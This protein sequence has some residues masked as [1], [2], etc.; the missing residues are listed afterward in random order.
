M[1]AGLKYFTRMQALLFQRRLSHEVNS[2]YIR[3]ANFFKA[4]NLP[5]CRIDNVDQRVTTDVERF[6]ESASA[7]LTTVSKPLL[8]VILL[9]TRLGRQ[10]GVHAPAVVIGASLLL[11]QLKLRLLPDVKRLAQLESETAGQ[12]RNAHARLI[13]AAEEIALF[14]GGRRERALLDALMARL[15]RAS[16]QLSRRQLLLSLIHI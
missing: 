7:L 5:Q 6:A 1:H 12:Y 4:S 2:K 15:F 13:A 14:H 11:S 8:D 3:G 10:L 16:V 9:T